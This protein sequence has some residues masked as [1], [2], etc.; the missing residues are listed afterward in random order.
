MIRNLLPSVAIIVSLS[1]A[2]QTD[3][4]CI[5]TGGYGA[6]DHLFEQELTYPVVALEAGIKGDVVISTSVDP[7]GKTI[8]VHVARGLCP[9]CDTEALRIMRLVNWRPATAGEACSGKELHIAVPFDPA[10]YKRWLKARHKRDDD[11]FSLPQDESLTIH[12]SRQL[13]TQMAPVIPNG[14]SGLPNHIAREMRYP[15]EAFRRSLEGTVKIEFVVEASGALSNMHVIEELGGGC[16]D[17][18][19]RLMHRIA[20]KPGVRD[21][22][23][24]RSS[25]QVSIRFSLPKDRR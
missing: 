1:S 8:G 9:E 11:V 19:I 4:V 6:L 12:T 7:S 25:L 20:W 21:G 24:V 5:P 2:A 10:R 13:E 18:A 22:K 15:P 14:M 3:G 17:E 16:V 23:R